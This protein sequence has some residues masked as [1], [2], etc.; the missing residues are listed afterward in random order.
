MNRNE[1]F[2]QFGSLRLFFDTSN[3]IQKCFVS[4][5]KYSPTLVFQVFLWLLFLLTVSMP[6][7]FLAWAHARKRSFLP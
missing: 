7:L 3:Y 2:S 5:F 1:I 4:A 6:V